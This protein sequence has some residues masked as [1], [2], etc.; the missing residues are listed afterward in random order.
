MTRTYSH[1]T[2]AEPLDRDQ[3]PGDPGDPAPVIDA[4]TVRATGGG[5]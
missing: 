2:V 5:R 4:A 3:P 1:I